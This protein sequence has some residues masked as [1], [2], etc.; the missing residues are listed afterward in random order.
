MARIGAAL[1]KKA[2]MAAF[3]AFWPGKWL[4]LVIDFP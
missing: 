4:F 1:A 3:S 2:P